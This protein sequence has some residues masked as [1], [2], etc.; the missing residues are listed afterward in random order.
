M[1]QKVKVE[2]EDA[3]F[4]G[5]KCTV[6]KHFSKVPMLR[7]H[8]YYGLEGDQL[9]NYGSDVFKGLPNEMTLSY[10]PPPVILQPFPSPGSA[11]V[12]Q[13]EVSV[14]GR[15]TDYESESV[16]VGYNVITVP[17]GKFECVC[18]ETTFELVNSMKITE[19]IWY[20]EDVGMVKSKT[21]FGVFELES[22]SD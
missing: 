15:M 7:R 8:Y 18:I 10:N 2:I 19:T 1:I 11:W 4:E 22:Y 16:V 6:F 17:A 3:T 13:G 5:K 12:S 21:Q 14:A 20:A 9:V